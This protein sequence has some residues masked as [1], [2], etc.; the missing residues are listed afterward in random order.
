MPI[1]MKF[2]DYLLL[3]KREVISDRLLPNSTMA[4]N[5]LASPFRLKHQTFISDSKVCWSSDYINMWSNSMTLYQTDIKEKLCSCLRNPRL[6]L[7][8]GH[9]PWVIS[10]AFI[11]S[12]TVNIPWVESHVRTWV[13]RHKLI[14]ENFYS[15]RKSQQAAEI[16]VCYTSWITIS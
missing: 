7:S 1:T 15:N 9:W 10:L 6:V 14:P 12:S 2:A 8:T 4:P 3:R 5:S 11:R 13:T 16:K